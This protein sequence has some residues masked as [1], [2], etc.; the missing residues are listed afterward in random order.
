MTEDQPANGM[1]EPGSEQVQRY[2]AQFE[3]YGRLLGTNRDQCQ[4]HIMCLMS[5]DSSVVVH[6]SLS[7]K[8]TFELSD[9]DII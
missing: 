5:V 7:Y 1:S 4:E 8:L 2:E 6:S 9:N 3:L